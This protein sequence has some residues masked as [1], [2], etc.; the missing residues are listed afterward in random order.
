MEIKE[1]TAFSALTYSKDEHR[2][3]RS[4]RKDKEVLGWRTLF[5]I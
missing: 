2:N 3:E 5:L 4:P 1:N